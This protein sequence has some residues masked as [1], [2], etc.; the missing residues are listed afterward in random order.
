[1]DKNLRQ[2][3]ERIISDSIKA[4]LPDEAVLRALKDFSPGKGRVL[5]AAAGKA[6]WQMAR[7]AVEALGHVDGG[8]VVT[9]YGH[10]MGEIP[11]VSCF[12]AGH[13]VP[14]SNSFAA[15]DRVLSLV[16]GLSEDDNVLFLLSGGG[17]A[18][19]EKPLIPGDELQD[20]TRQLLACG[21]DIT[22]I[23]TIRK[24]LSAV[25]GGRFAL[26]CSPAR[27]FSIV[28]SDIIG[29]PLDMIASGPACPDSSTCAQAMAI[30]EKYSLSLSPVAL[31]LLGKETPKALNNVTTRITG[32]VRELCAA[33]ADS[34]RRLG[35]QP[36]LLTDRLDCEAREA[37]RFLAA[38]LCSHVG[39]SR[40][41]A[42]I[43]G[44]ETVVHLTGSGLGGRNQELALAAALGISGING[45]AVFSV[46]SDGTDGPT[47]AAGG[48]VD[49]DTLGELTAKGLVLSAVL[50]ANDAYNG[51]KAVGGLI[52]TGPTGTNVNDV[53]V[54]LLR[55]AGE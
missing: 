25:K 14:D 39:D 33:A 36:V 6:A 21:A 22:E 12:E 1:M 19:F 13:P 17:S 40:S 18:L 47:D 8:V 46:G 54:A 51:L 38:V 20:I 26:A 2:D 24:R 29:D 27:V 52:I 15:T 32:S 42:F 4:V 23:N 5:L 16:R 53:S 49:G 3:A 35:Y 30:F 31:S 7:A 9:K 11:N 45:A 34:C 28:L 50:K 43:V 10:I 37:G 55:K 48:Y 44:G 41:L